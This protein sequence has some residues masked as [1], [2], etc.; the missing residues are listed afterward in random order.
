[1]GGQLIP[2]VEAP[3]GGAIG[4][5][6]CPGAP[7]HDRGALRRDIESFRAIG[8]TALVGNRQPVTTRDQRVP[9]RRRS[10]VGSRGTFFRAMTRD[11]P[12]PP[13][14]HDSRQAQQSGARRHSPAGR[15]GNAHG[16]ERDPRRYRRTS[17]TCVSP[18]VTSTSSRS[19]GR[20]P[21]IDLAFHTST[22]R[23][24]DVAYSW[25][26]H[27]LDAHASTGRVGLPDH[28]MLLVDLAPA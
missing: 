28:A 19:G 3:G 25:D 13:R 12:R 21:R 4:M 2:F 22:L 15:S 11:T 10:R 17:S 20:G 8:V 27:A 16:P 5:S 18:T 23:C 1:M 24:D 6:P 14:D 7:A 26:F 9:R